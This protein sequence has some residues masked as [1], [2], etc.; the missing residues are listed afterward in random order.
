MQRTLTPVLQPPYY[1]V[2]FTSIHTPNHEG[3]DEMGAKMAQ[4]TTEQKGFMGIEGARNED[5][6]GI[7]VCYWKTE[8]DI[9]NWKKNEEHLLAQQQG[10]EKWYEQYSIRI[11]KVERAYE[12]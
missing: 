10:K 5:G 2:I 1:A 7:T 9:R 3:Y 4:L 11:C 8:E 12:F 6:M